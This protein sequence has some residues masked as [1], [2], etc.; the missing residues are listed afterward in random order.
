MVE[1]WV[2][3]KDAR[4][5]QENLLRSHCAGVG[6]TFARD[7]ARAM[8]VARVN[9]LARGY[10]AIRPDVVGRLVDFLNRFRSIR[11]RDDDTIATAAVAA[12]FVAKFLA[13]LVEEPDH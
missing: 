11:A 4:A 5:L 13:V 10:S 7:E 1:N 6:E 3:L 12:D 2:E 8:M 9:S